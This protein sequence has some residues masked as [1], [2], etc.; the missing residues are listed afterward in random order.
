MFRRFLQFD[1]V[2][3]SAVLLL[4][5]MSILVLYGFSAEG[6]PEY[7]LRQSIFVGI[8][9]LVSLFLASLDYRH[10]GRHSTLLYFSMLGILLSVLL[11]GKTIRGTEG[12]IDL[13]FTQ[14]QPVEF[15][16]VVLVLFLASFIAKKTSE[17][18]EWTRL[19]ASL[20]LTGML[21]FLVMRQPDLGS[22]IVL[23]GVWG[24]M[25]L[26]SGIR[27]KHIV[28]LSIL[29]SLLVS[30]SWFFLADYQ[31]ARIE[32]FMH[33]ELDPKGS[34]YN[35]LQAMVAV[36]SGG[37]F[38]KGIG[39]GTQSQ[40]NFLPEK[41]TDFI[42]ASINEE[43]GMAGAFLTLFLYGVIFY[44][45][46]TIGIQASDNFGYLITVGVYAIVLVQ[47]SINIGMNVGLLPVTGIP[48]PFMS[49]GGSSVLSLFIGIG[50]VQN[51]YRLRRGEQ[52]T[53]SQNRSEGDYIPLDYHL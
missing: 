8:G 11:F 9:F 23:L 21:V 1:W 45:L 47:V 46:R 43:L 36:G 12:W 4:S 3:F 38:G 35:V 17:L 29:G 39:H 50:I 6:K 26:I 41:H 53:V 37:V 28:V 24:M 15:A 20:I 48:L 18:G 10:I 5:G 33:P 22:S 52:Y 7:F 42:F 14:V 30:G 31:R 34:G 49:Y 13:G 2:L 32:S 40:S 27:L 25:L 16:K 51:V 19:I 44:R